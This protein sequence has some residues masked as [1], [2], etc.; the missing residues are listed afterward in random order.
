MPG[1]PARPA[2][3]GGSARRPPRARPGRARALVEDVDRAGAG[4]ERDARRRRSAARSR[5]ARRARARGRR[6]RQR[7]G[8]AWGAPD[9]R[10]H[11]P[12]EARGGARGR[13]RRGRPPRRARRPRPPGRA[14]AARRPSRRGGRPPSSAASISSRVA[15]GARLLEPQPQA[16]E[17]RAQL[18]RGV[19]DELALAVDEALEPRAHLVER[20]R[21]ALLL[22][23]SPRPARGRA[24]R[25][26]PRRA[27]ASSRRRSGRAIWRAIS[28]PA[29]RPSSEHEHAD[30]DEAEVERRVA[31]PTASTLWVIR[32]APW[33][34]A[35]A[36]ATGTAVARIS[37]SSVSERRWAW[38]RRPRRAAAIS[39]RSL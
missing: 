21:E 29:P 39:G 33:G 38:K 12:V 32:T 22:G 23:A 6:G 3:R 17:R 24:G 37:S 7:T 1:G 26:R 20:A 2:G 25:P 35:G 36:R 11:A 13:R 27:A 16:G 9:E 18:V 19:G 34:A 30:R 8:A 15:G 31:R 5:S 14:A 10:G 4:D 28:A